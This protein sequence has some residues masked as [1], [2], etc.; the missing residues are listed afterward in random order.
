MAEDGSVDSW[1]CPYKRDS[2]VG[3]TATDPMLHS[4]QSQLM[5]REGCNV[6]QE[7][8]KKHVSNGVGAVD[9]VGELTPMREVHRAR[10]VHKR[11]GKPKKTISTPENENGAIMCKVKEKNKRY[12]EI[13][14]EKACINSGL[15]NILLSWE[16]LK[17]T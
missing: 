8:P 14:S 1:E 17:S 10:E 2:E 3:I 13:R 12:S 16:Y 9:K 15:T 5:A 6:I 4:Q 11:E 7:I